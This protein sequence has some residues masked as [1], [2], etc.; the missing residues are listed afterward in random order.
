MRK[1]YQLVRIDLNMIEDKDNGKSIPVYMPIDPAR[2]EFSLG[3]FSSKRKVL[4]KLIEVQPKIMKKGI[5]DK[6]FYSG[7]NSRGYWEGWLVYDPLF[8]RAICYM[9]REIEAE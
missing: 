2:P 5:M 4:D 3:Y 8:T 7:Y 9:I 1:F 6:P